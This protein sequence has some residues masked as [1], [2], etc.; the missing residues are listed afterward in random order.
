MAPMNLTWSQIQRLRIH[1]ALTRMRNNNIDNVAILDAFGNH[2]M[3][4]TLRLS[5]IESS[6]R[7]GLNWPA[8]FK[9]RHA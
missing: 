9:Q 8:V 5:F 7:L 4:D 3:A 6:D 2:W 1:I